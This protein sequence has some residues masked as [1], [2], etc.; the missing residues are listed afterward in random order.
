MTIAVPRPLTL[1][2]AS[3][4]A[5]EAMAAVALA[6]SHEVVGIL[7]DDPDQ[8]GATLGGVPV[9]GPLEQAAT[10][11]GD[12]L[13]CAGSGRARAA[14]AERLDL[15]DSR[16]A[17]VVHPGAVV[18]PGCTIGPG[19]ILLAQV[20]LTADVSVGRHVVA[21]PHVVLTHD[22]VV[23]DFATLCAG[24]VLGGTVRVGRGAYLGMNA[25]VRENLT[26]GAGSVLGMGSVLLSSL[27]DGAT[28]AGAPAAALRR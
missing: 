10:E 25:A 16:W 2:A 5:R 14:I 9:S 20:V 12:L 21:M 15:D 8:W 26:V 18:P 22:D 27:P 4:L 28:W 3:G 13:I 23:E 1:L 17:T 6:G 7:D 11:P 19:S 24:V